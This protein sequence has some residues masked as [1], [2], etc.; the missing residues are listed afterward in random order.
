M[1]FLFKSLYFFLVDV[2]IF[3]LTPPPIPLLASTLRCLIEGGGE[4]GWKNSKN[5]IDG[6]VGK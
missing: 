4:G 6:G 1:F 2:H 3:H 5:L